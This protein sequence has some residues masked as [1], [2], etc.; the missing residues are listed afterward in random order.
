MLILITPFSPFKLDVIVFT[1]FSRLFCGYFI[2]WLH[3]IVDGYFYSGPPCCDAGVGI[4][5]GIFTKVC[6]SFDDEN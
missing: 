3:G 1:Q 4:N 5:S 6:L 2:V